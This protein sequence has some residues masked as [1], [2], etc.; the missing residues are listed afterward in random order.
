MNEKEKE[1]EQQSSSTQEKTYFKAFETEDEF[2]KY[3]QS[4]SSKAKGDILK[5]IGSGSVADIKE[6]IS[7]GLQHGDLNKE[8]E[9]AKSQL[10]QLTTTKTELEDK[11]IVSKYGVSEEFSKQFL[12][13]ARSGINEKVTL[14]QSAEQVV[15]ALKKN[16]FQQG[17]G[18]V[19]KIGSQQ[20][21]SQD[22][23]DPTLKQ[24]R[25]AMGLDKK[26]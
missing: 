6:K 13:L 9:D 18:R 12:T 19:V 8:L 23:T 5:E 7:L 11:Y 20:S 1:Q 17:T 4:I 10:E 16:P 22:L 2:N 25:A 26:K 21:G 14:E 15:E 3:T 24:I